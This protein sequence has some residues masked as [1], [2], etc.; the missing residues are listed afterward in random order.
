[1]HFAFDALSSAFCSL[2]CIFLNVFLMLF[3]VWVRTQGPHEPLL[4]GGP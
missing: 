3:W 1:M 4:P 2:F